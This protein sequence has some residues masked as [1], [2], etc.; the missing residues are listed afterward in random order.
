MTGHLYRT[1]SQFRNVFLLANRQEGTRAS[2]RLPSSACWVTAAEEPKSSPRCQATAGK[3]FKEFGNFESF[4]QKQPGR[5]TCTILDQVPFHS[6]IVVTRERP[7]CAH[8]SR[9]YSC[10]LR[11]CLHPVQPL[12]RR[13]QPGSS[14]AMSLTRMALSYPGPRSLCKT[15]ERV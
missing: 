12:D 2:T 7:I 6:E 14:T 11:C 13:R 10:A 3:E 15:W 4:G 1:A 5:Q 9:W 8:G